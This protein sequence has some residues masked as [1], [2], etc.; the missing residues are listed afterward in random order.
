MRRDHAAQPDAANERHSVHHPHGGGCGIVTMPQGGRW[1]VG[2]RLLPGNTG[3]SRQRVSEHA[4]APTMKEALRAVAPGTE[5]RDGLERILRG[6]TG[7]LVVLGW[8]DQVAQLC[9]DGI[10]L[11]VEFSATRL[12]E[13]AKMDGAVVVDQ[14]RGRIV[15]ANV[16]LTPDT[17][18]PTTET[19]MRHRTAARVAR[20]TGL[21]VITVSK[22]MEVVA[23]FLGA[24]R[25]VLEPSTAILGRANQAIATLERYTTRL[26][27]VSRALTALEF[28]DMVTIR[29]VAVVLQRLEMVRRIAA[30]IDDYVAELG[31]DGRLVAL[32]LDEL[33]R[34]VS[35]DRALVLRDY[36]AYPSELAA[37]ESHLTWLNSSE[38][39]DFSIVARALGWKDPQGLG[40]DMPV[41][42]RGHRMLARI[43]RVPSVVADSII[44]QLGPLPAILR[45]NEE[46][47]LTVDG[48]GPLRA[49]AV[50]DGLDRLAQ[51]T[52][53]D[54]FV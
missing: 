2:P 6:R 4:S 24:E 30:E 15:R 20:Q 17:A 16:Q 49:R 28:T 45:A 5:V 41:T 50:H 53:I 18:I 7:A 48:V 8:N 36:V 35:R 10:E 31:T 26:E 11:D 21:P 29:D 1:D 22:S 27:E 40:L 44:A 25:H 12:R 34:G 9:S 32:Q 38:L 42:P 39:V 54:R 47:L 13:L 33:N 43:P 46:D 3:G 19:G 52:V 51:V 14:A 23:L 37:A